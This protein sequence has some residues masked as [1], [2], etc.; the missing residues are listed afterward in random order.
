MKRHVFVALFPALVVATTPAGANNTAAAQALFEEGRALMGKGDF[1]AACAKL[2]GSQKLDPGPGTEYNL[3]VCYDKSGRSAS[4][5]AT[6]LSAAAAY[7]ATA[8]P[9]WEAKART[10]AAAL[11]GNLSRLTILAA[12]GHEADTRVT[13]DG[14]AL[15]ASEL[16]AAIP[17]DPGPHLVEATS[18]RGERWRQSVDVPAGQTVSV[19]VT[20]GEA[21][22]SDDTTGASSE[23]PAARSPQRTWAFVLGGVGVAGVAAGAITG[24]V[25]IS[26]NGTAKAKCPVDGPCADQDALRANDAARSWATASTA[27]FSVGGALLA[28]GVILWATAASPTGARVTPTLGL[29]RVGAVVRW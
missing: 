1:I 18:R 2:E 9:E 14:V 12:A 22:S 10:R 5:W 19:N 11:A 24:L 16:G 20:F 6:Y 4:A 8:R 26:E 17:V 3:A 28:T 15:V 7:K 13:R 21:P 25:A 27:T 23:E 29:G